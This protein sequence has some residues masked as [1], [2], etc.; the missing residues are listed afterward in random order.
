MKYKIFVSSVIKEFEKERKFIKQEIETDY[1]LNRFFDVFLF[2][3]Y[4]A[5]GLS[6]EELYSE[7][8]I[9]S[10]IYIGLIGSDYGS[11]LESGIS[12][13]ELEYDL[14]NKTHNDALIYIK[15]VDFRD[16]KTKEF[17]EKIGTHS[18]TKFKDRYDLIKQIKESLAN[19]IDKNLRNY[20]AFDYEILHDSSCDD[21]D[22]EAVDLFFNVLEYEPIEN[23]RDEKGLK[24]VLSTIRAG[25]YENGKFRLNTAGALFF[26]KDIS[27]FN[28]SHQVKM[29]RFFDD[30]GI[31]T[32]EKAEYNLSFLKLLK[33][34]ELFFNKTLTNVSQIKG[35]KREIIQDYPFEA[36][37]EALVNALAHRNYT[38]AT[39]P[40]TFYIYNDRIEIKSPGRLVYPLT[41]SG[42]EKDGPIH[43]NEAICNIFSKTRYM[44]HVGNGIKRMK[45]A[46]RA[47]GL[48]EPE[49]T[50]SGEFFKVTFRAN[51]EHIGLN[52]RQKEFLRGSDKSEITIKEYMAMFGIVR[53]TAT[54]DL[55]ELTD[56]RMLEKIKIGK[57]IIYK[58]ID[59]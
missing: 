15:E 14:Y 58:K 40:I 50:E 13:T 49:F 31:N 10:D 43:R 25:E 44:E 52:D 45:D 1:I 20:R 2:E 4:S 55:N 37:R 51:D 53:N 34:A 48:D 18:Y 16:D 6:P 26:A 47:H 33:E 28:I 42:L 35:F 11:I 32:F 56:K 3:E 41:I 27:K 21:V 38:I 22:M 7:E 54:K 59:D 57:Q 29:V 12:P 17:I 30:E 19:F 39:A 36:I 9:N 46:M 5:S 8:V 24:N 23:I